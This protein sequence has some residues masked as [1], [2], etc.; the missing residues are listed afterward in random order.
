MNKSVRKNNR[1]KSKTK[2]SKMMRKS[3]RSKMMR[4]SK[5][6]KM[7]RKSRRSKMMRKSRRS[8]TNRMVGGLPSPPTSKMQRFSSGTETTVKINDIICKNCGQKPEDGWKIQTVKLNTAT[9]GYGDSKGAAAKVGRGFKR[10]VKGTANLVPMTIVP[11]VGKLLQEE[12]TL[13]TCSLCNDT[14]LVKTNGKTERVDE[15][16]ESRRNKSMDESRLNTRFKGSEKEQNEI[17]K[18]FMTYVLML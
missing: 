6:S 15:W 11:V 2:R 9:T 14:N 16:F 3:R 7:M 17:F 5:R 18:E 8:T 13:I 12:F 4:K 1:V 10:L